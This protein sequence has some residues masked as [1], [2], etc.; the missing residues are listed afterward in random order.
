[1]RVAFLVAGQGRSGGMGVIRAHARHLREHEGIEAVL[2][3]VGGAGPPSPTRRTADVPVR[4]LVSLDGT[5]FDVAVATWWTTADHLWDVPA[6]ARAVLL[7]SPDARYYRE[8]EAP[9]RLGATIVL[10]LPVHWLVVSERL[11]TTVRVVAPDARVWRV[12]PGI[13][14]STFKPAPPCDGGPRS[15]GSASRPVTSPVDGGPLRVLVEGQ[16]SLWFKAVPEAVAAVRAMSAPATVTVVAP[17]P[18]GDLGADRV[19]GGLG[20]AGMAALY[21]EH[22]VLLK[23]SRFEGLGLPVLEAFHVGRPC[24]ATPFGDLVEHGVNGLVAGFDDG[25]GT[26]A[27]LDRLASDPA[28]RARLGEGALATAAAWPDVHA[29]SA[30]FADALRELAAA[31]SPAAEPALG[32]LAH[33]RRAWIEEERGRLARSRDAAATWEAAYRDADAKN[34]EYEAWTRELQSR[35]ETLHRGLGFR[36]EARLRRLLGR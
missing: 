16:P 30:A 12:P 24:V 11:E 13:D 5:P 19:A 18:A 17:E 22:D 35:I 36:T 23:L 29:G 4:S 21:A 33:A 34:A 32:R 9:D 6:T 26:V 20:P 10:A 31:P 28:L 7:Q 15:S 8:H 1:M 14:K 27:A 3:D 2:V 25:P